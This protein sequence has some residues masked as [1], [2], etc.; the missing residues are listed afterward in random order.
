MPSGKSGYESSV[1]VSV[2]SVAGMSLM[3][4]ANSI[5]V[6]R[7]AGPEGRGLYG[8]T[9]AIGALALPLASAGLGSATTW[10]LGRGQPYAQLLGLTHRAVLASLAL[11]LVTVG[12]AVGGLEL[13]LDEAAMWGLLAAALALPAQVTIE[14]ARGLMLGQRRAVAY[15]LSSA[16]VIAVMLGLNLSWRFTAPEWFGLDP[17]IA[18]S[19]WVLANLV[20]ANWIIAAWMVATSLRQSSERPTPELLRGSLSYGMRSAMVALGDAAL[21]RVDYLVAAPF[22]DLAALGIYAIADQISHLMAWVGLLA[23]RMMLPEAAS[24]EA[25]GQRSLA[26]LGLACRLIVFVT[27]VGAA[28]AIGVGRWLIELLFGPSFTDAY[29]AMLILLPATLFKSLHAL[30][31]T[32]LQG[33]ADQRPVVRAS[34]I[35]VA[36]EAVAVAGLAI[37]MGWLGVAV[38]KTGAYAVQLGLGLVALRRHRAALP[39]DDGHWIPGGRWLITRDDVT[40]VRG[41]LA[42]RKARRSSPTTPANNPE[43][44]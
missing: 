34:A 2:V 41:R 5:V 6:A 12:V 19:I 31:A 23:G 40:M 8:L 33:R 14:I 4:L 3:A 26:K 24:D 32:W 22:V 36:L 35:S 29:V 7:A 13:G 18:S 27:L 39:G 30:I 21:L 1:L 44:D 38:A 20:L 9:V 10:Q 42:A 16:I 11:G 25:D 15:N 17:E 43:N 28:I 37:T